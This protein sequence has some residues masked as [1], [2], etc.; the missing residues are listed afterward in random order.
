[1]KLYDIAHSRA[2]DKGNTS[3]LSLIPFDEND[4]DLLCREITADK[5]KMHLSGI[6]QGEVIRY[7]MPNISALLFVCRDALASGVTTSLRS[8]IHG[9]ALSYKLLDMDF[10]PGLV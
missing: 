2:G 10:L 3:T 5:V 8:D 1:M 7:E 9:K 4:Y 6:V